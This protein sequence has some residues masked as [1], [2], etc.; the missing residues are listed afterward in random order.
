MDTEEADIYFLVDGSS[1]IHWSDFNEM[2]NFLK[3]VIKLFNVGPNH[4]RF[5]VVQ[6]SSASRIKLHFK[7]DDY[8]KRSTL[9]KAINNVNQLTGDTYTGE[10]LKFMQ[11]LFEKA[12]RQ[13][14]NQVPCHLIVLT[15]GEAHDDVKVPAEILRN[16]KVTIHAI[17]VKDANKTQLHEMAGSRVYSV[18]Q[19]DSLKDI[20]AEVVRDLCTEEG[21]RNTTSS[22][23]N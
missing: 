16:A 3:E 4:V 10:A 14:G 15:D 13:R 7:L 11:P 1:S 2:K 18:Q 17:G 23:L 8:T 22:S 21:K 5:G 20:Q 19:F 6:Y 9:E 12:R